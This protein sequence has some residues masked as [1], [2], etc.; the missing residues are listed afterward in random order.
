MTAITAV[1]LA[2]YL[3]VAIRIFRSDKLADVSFSSAAVAQALA[4]QTRIELDSITSSLRLIVQGFDFKTNDLNQAAKALFKNEARVETLS[5]YRWG[6]NS[7]YEKVR[8]IQQENLPPQPLQLDAQQVL[9][10]SQQ[11]TY[12]DVLPSMDNKVVIGVRF[13]KLD[14]PQHLVVIA[15]VNAPAFSD[16][17]SKAGNYTNVLVGPHAKVLLANAK[18]LPDFATWDLISDVQG[19]N[20]P[21]GT[22]EVIDNSSHR[23][24]L[25]AYAQV[26]FGKLMMLSFV[27]KK[28]A[29]AAV[30]LLVTKS[31]LLFIALLSLTIIVALIS[32]KQIT[33]ALSRLT[34]A[35]QVVA[36]GKFDIKINIDS[37]DEIGSLAKSFNSMAEKLSWYVVQVAEKAVLE[38]ELNTAKTVQDTLF[39]PEHSRLDSLEISGRYQPASQCGGDWWYYCRVGER[40]FMWIGD[41]TGH[42]VPAALVTSAA[43]SAASIIEIMPTISP[44]QALRMMNRAI[45]DTS[46]GKMLMTFFIASFDANTG[47]LVYANASH[48]PPFLFRHS[49]ATLKKQDLIPLNEVNDPRLGERSDSEYHEARIFIAPGDRIFFYT[50]GMPDIKN[51][52]GESWGERTLVKNVITAFNQGRDTEIVATKLQQQINEFRGGTKLDDDVTFF[53]CQVGKAA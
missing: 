4:S 35:S 51:P 45:H 48:E 23:P 11:E 13:G 37:N 7:A 43:R 33:Q 42:G 6:A 3:Y 14:S 18:G 15:L 8:E 22:A 16:S 53:V 1:T 38:S 5:I 9:H 50:D 47:E 41:A 20:V 40:I 49:D 19:S 32:S 46:K 44:G 39:P 29:L 52:A 12:V 27:P 28:D 26:G 10:I 24:I 31:V 2:L 36:T 25:A 34:E 30:S 21:P 17:I